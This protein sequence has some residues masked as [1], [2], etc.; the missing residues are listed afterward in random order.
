MGKFKDFSLDQA[1]EYMLKTKQDL[2][3]GVDVQEDVKQLDLIKKLGK[4]GA[5]M[6]QN[7]VY[8]ENLSLHDN[9][10][11]EANKDP[12]L[13]ATIQKSTFNPN[14]PFETP[15]MRKQKAIEEQAQK[16]VEEK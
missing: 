15:M 8:D 6:K 2:A 16:L 5:M 1:A 12:E 4:M 14:D 13:F 11:T 9:V 7:G 10:L 3:N